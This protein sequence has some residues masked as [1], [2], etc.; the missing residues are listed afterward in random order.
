M[1][2]NKA[3]SYHVCL[4]LSLSLLS[5]VAL[6]RPAHAEN[7]TKSTNKTL[8]EN[9]KNKKPT[10][11][12][13]SKIFEMPVGNQYTKQPQIPFGAVSRTRATDGSFEAKYKKIRDLIKSDRKLN[14][15]IK[16][17]SLKFGI[18]PI[19][20]VGALVGE[21]TYN[22]DALDHIQTYLVKAASY[23]D[24]AISFQYGGEHVLKFVERPQFERCENIKA[25]YQ[26]WDCREDIWKTKF[27]GKKVDGTKWPKDRFGRV[28]FQPLYAGQTFG[29]GQ[30]NPLTALRVDDL[31]RATKKSR[32]LNAK[33]APNVYKAI[34]DPKT[35]I[36]YMAAVIKTS[37]IAYRDV[38]GID[39]STNPG[40]TAT[41]Y[42]L[43]DVYD[44]AKTLK[45]KRLA[46]VKSLPKENYYG[47]LVNNKLSELEQLIR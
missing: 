22:V 28:F 31:V 4:L 18:K 27:S 14:A 21:H 12:K 23:F 11:Q 1:K 36:D 5:G 46:Y 47:W 24:S 15:A 26:R 2:S 3:L 37:I 25:S 10:A 38:A 17:S 34:M 39:I 7:I 20:I 45:R 6:L 41:L 16:K 8:T 19:H 43:G 32:P 35:S 9:I 13:Q 33:N 44:R 29:L 42:N 30:L 40:I